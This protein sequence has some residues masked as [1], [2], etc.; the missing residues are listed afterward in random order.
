VNPASYF[1]QSEQLVGFLKQEGEKEIF[2]V[3]TRNSQ[4]MIM[5]RNQGM[6]DRLF[7]MEGYAPL[8]LQRSSFPMTMQQWVDILNIKYRTVTNEQTHAISLTQTDSYFQRAFFL[9]N[10]HVVH[11]EEELIAY[12]KSPAFDHRITAVLE[13]DPGRSLQ[14]PLTPPTWKTR[15]S[16]YTNNEISIETE[17]SHDGVLVL[18]EMYY[19]GWNAYVDGRET[20]LFQADYNLRGLFVGKGS[21][22]I[23]VRFEPPP[24]KRGA[25]LTVIALVVCVL[26]FFISGSR[27]GK[28]V[29]VGGMASR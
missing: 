12:I 14:T 21:H 17:T 18:S 5:D 27:F 25:L 11:N 6:I 23:D 13:K 1:S 10:V 29:H 22:H 16:G 7:T 9:Y 2:R 4:G 24:Y 20:E 8:A 26:G 15:I 3:S 28:R 19:P